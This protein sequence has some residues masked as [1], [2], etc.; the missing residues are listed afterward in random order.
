MRFAPSA[1]FV[2]FVSVSLLAGCAS[3][4]QWSP[5][6]DTYGNSRAQYLSRDMEECRSLARSASGG[7]GEQAA[8]GAGIGGLA[9]AAGG[10]L[11]G[12]MVGRPG[13]GAVLGAA[14]GAAGGGVYSGTRTEQQ[15]KQAF[16]NCMRQRGHNVIN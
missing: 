1:G 8:K 16:S 13:R 9:G 6:V 10:A 5:T 14:A 4:S 7:T 11:I 12:T 3:Q 2:I 15:F